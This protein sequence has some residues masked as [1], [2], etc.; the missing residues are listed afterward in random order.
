MFISSTVVPRRQCWKT[1]LVGWFEFSNSC[2]R[3]RVDE[4]SF[5][6]LI[7]MTGLSYVFKFEQLLSTTTPN[8]GVEL[9]PPSTE[10]RDIKNAWK[11]VNALITPRH[12]LGLKFVSNAIILI[13]YSI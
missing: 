5:I 3:S 11:Y 4:V 9:N 13:I 8:V 7:V 10:L 12:S 2:N 1:G 6:P